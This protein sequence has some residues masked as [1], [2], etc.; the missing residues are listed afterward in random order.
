[1][2]QEF[3]VAAAETG[4]LAQVLVAVGDR[5]KAG[6]P[7]ARLDTAVLEREIA[8]AEARL[9]QISAE[10]GAAAAVMESD[11]YSSERNF[12][13][14]VEDAAAQIESA[15]AAHNA[16]Q[17]ELRTLR[18]E[19][20]RLR[21]LVR[22]GL[23]RADRA[24]EIDVR[25]RALE[26]TAAG[27]PARLAA[28]TER[29]RAAERRL[30]D[31]RTEHQ[32]QSAPRS[33]DARL[34]PVRDRIGEQREALR[35]LRARLESATILAPADGEVIALYARQGDVATPAAPV[36]LLHGTGPRL[37]VAYVNERARPA[38]GTKALGRRRT[39]AREEVEVKVARVSDAVVQLP[40][41]FW[42]LPTMPL[43]GREVYLELPA[44]ARL[45][46]GEAVDIRF[47]TGGV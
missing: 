39:L 9:R 41:R 10:P 21:R 31:W 25:V 47:T 44:N 22:E 18:D 30:A 8:A 26:E 5:V 2:P 42:I 43:W 20:T 29:L 32:A 24:E 36:L 33:R 27:W 15:R 38:V 23:T 28:L 16:Q 7:V 17:A 4:R 46:A 34:Q 14:D 1:V 3:R 11:D 40:P 45:D 19:A 13:A 12:Q 6:Q 35:V 37:L